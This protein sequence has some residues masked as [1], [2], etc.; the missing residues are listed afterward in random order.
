MSI[1]R[2][3]Y[4]NQKSQETNELFTVCKKILPRGKK[5]HNLYECQI[6]EEH[7]KEKYHEFDFFLTNPDIEGVYETQIPLD[8]HF[9]TKIGAIAKLDGKNIMKKKRDTGQIV[10]EFKDFRPIFSQNK[11]YLGNYNMNYIYIA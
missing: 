7:F 6:S 8:Y 3:I 11:E 9:I 4:I 2:V 1:P 10:Y 5:R